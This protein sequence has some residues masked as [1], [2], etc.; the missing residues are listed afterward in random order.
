MI[1]AL[2]HLVDD[3]KPT[4]MH[5]Y[6]KLKHLQ[7]E[8]VYAPRGNHTGRS[9]VMVQFDPEGNVK[10]VYTSMR[11]PIVISMDGWSTDGGGTW[12]NAF[13]PEEMFS[14]IKKADHVKVD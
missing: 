12:A 5:R 9:E 4:S 3:G 13:N 11:N 7:T 8:D 6:G 2:P 14:Q 10:R 1:H